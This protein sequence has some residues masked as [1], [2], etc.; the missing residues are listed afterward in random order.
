MFAGLPVAL[1]RLRSP[2]AERFEAILLPATFGATLRPALLREPRAASRLTMDRPLRWKSLLPTAARR[3]PV[4]PAP[5]T[6]ASLFAGSILAVRPLT[7]LER[8]LTR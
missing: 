5:R 4:R 8:L 1:I 3:V 2:P 6:L 7:S